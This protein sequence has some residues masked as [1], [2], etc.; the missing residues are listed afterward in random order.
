LVDILSIF[1]TGGSIDEA[2]LDPNHDDYYAHSG[3]WFDVQDSRWLLD[4]TAQ[5][6]LSLSV[7][8]SG[9]VTSGVNGQACN[10]SCTTEWDAGTSIELV[11]EA[12]PGFGFVSWTGAC[13][14]AP[15]SIC[16]VDLGATTETGAVFRPL[17]RLAL[18]ITGR[19]TIT[20]AHVRCSRS[21][22]TQRAEGSRVTLHAKA[23]RG[24]RFVRWSGGCRASRPACTLQL[25]S[26]G[27]KALAVFA[28]RA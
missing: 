17:R 9:F 15:D 1:Y 16:F 6:Q 11:A 13:A 3:S 8:G 5:V 12:L 7:S 19:G 20:G 18:Q 14:G 26:G 25:G 10:G 23:A 28:R 21:C 24:W 2:L 4:A 27:A 22:S